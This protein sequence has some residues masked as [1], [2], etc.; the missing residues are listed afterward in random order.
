MTRPSFDDLGLATA[1][2]W[3]TRSADPKVQVGACILDRHNRVVGVGYNGRAAGEPN[4]RESLAHGASGFIHA[5]VN[6]LLAANWNGEGHTLYVTHEPCSVCARLIVNSRRVSR[7][8]FAAPYQEE[9]RVSAGL[10]GGAEILQT[11]GIL[12]QEAL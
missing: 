10:P 3:A 7:V 5:E 8:V 11:A 6:A 9:A 2:L 12:V 4:E 1:R